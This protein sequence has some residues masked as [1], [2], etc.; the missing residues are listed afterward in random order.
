[1]PGFSKL[2]T[3]D[4]TLEDT[5]VVPH[6]LDRLQ[7]A[8]RVIVAGAARNDIVQSIVP[9]DSDPRNQLT[10]SLTE[11]ASGVI[12]ILDSNYI[13]SN[14]PTPEDTAAIATN[15]SG[16]SF[17]GSFS[18]SFTGDGS[19]LSGISSEWNGILVGNAQITG[20]L[21]VT[22]DITSSGTYNGVLHYESAATDPASPSPSDG[23]RYYN[24]SLEMEMRYD[25][26]RSKWLSVETC[27]FY[28]A[29]KGDTAV[30]SYFKSIAEVTLSSTIGRTLE[31]DG[32]IISISYT[33]TDNDSATFEATADGVTIATLASSAET[34]TDVTLDSDFSQG[35]I[36]AARN[37]SG[38][39]KI[40]DALGTIRFK[41]RAT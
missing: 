16:S 35:N 1:M 18:G 2:Y 9:S 20:T 36:L 39:N 28:F 6:G 17:S 33:R 10:I 4:F 15:V 27:E 13:F 32:T 38:G 34:G 37:Q 29:R 26:T 12:Q 30:G 19:E 14:I 22:S 11:T 40:K 3:Q 25:G 41:W 7:T 23:D 31:F 8:C 5:I 24:T 21:G